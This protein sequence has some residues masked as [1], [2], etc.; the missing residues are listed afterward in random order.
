MKTRFSFLLIFLCFFLL[1]PGVFSATWTRATSNNAFYFSGTTTSSSNKLAGHGSTYYQVSGH[2]SISGTAD[3]LKAGDEYEAEAWLE[4]SGKDVAGVPGRG[5]IKTNK[6]DASGANYDEH[7]TATGEV[8]YKKHVVASASDVQLL[9]GT[10]K[11]KSLSVSS[12]HSWVGGSYTSPSGVSVSPYCYGRLDGV[13]LKSTGGATL[14]PLTLRSGDNPASDDTPDDGKKNL[15]AEIC[16]RGEDCGKPGTATKDISHRVKCGEKRWGNNILLGAIG[17]WKKKKEDCPGYIWTCADPAVCQFV[18]S[19]V[20]A[21]E[22]Q[23]EEKYVDKDGKTV[24]KPAGTD[25]D[26]S[27]S[28]ASLSGSGSASAGSTYKVTLTTPKPFRKLYWYVRVP[29]ASK[30]KLLTTM[31]GGSSST[32]ASYTYYLANSAPAGNHVL[33]VLYYD[34]ADGEAS[35]IE[36]TVSVTSKLMACGHAKGTP[37]NHNYVQC[38]RAKDGARCRADKKHPGYHLACDTSHVHQYG[39]TSTTP[40]SKPKDTTPTDTTPRET[41]PKD[42]TPKETQPQPKS[43]T[44][45]TPTPT[46]PTPTTPTPTTPTPTT[47]VPQAPSQVTYHA[48]GVH[49]SSVSGDHSLQAS[50]SEDSKCIATSFYKCQHSSHTYPVVSLRPCGHPTTRW[51]SHSWVSAGKCSYYNSDGDRCTNTSGYYMCKPHTHEYP[52][53]KKPDPPPK[54]KSACPAD[55]WTNCGGTV[56]HAATCQAGHTYY[57]C[58]PSAVSAHSRH[59]KPVPKSDV[60]CSSGHRYD[61]ES[62][63]AVN[64]HRVRT[65]RFSACGQTWQ[66]CVDVSAPICSKPYRKKNGLSCW[67]K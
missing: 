23:L 20:S 30:S 67:A 46:T 52:A 13:L 62:D 31:Q 63:F 37:G 66:R 59:K 19:H 39:P 60:V 28:S 61:P 33:N 47:P 14:T 64:K 58:N 50:C 38:P 27:S 8:V 43:P 15:V 65:C 40:V 11:A 3:A 1:T 35:Y 12:S 36:H 4:T 2:A 57:T 26:S 10:Y 25:D 29:G 54:P 9:R 45:T 18:A 34:Y 56:S 16:Q 6:K 32:S 44:P 7:R 17:V 5:N 55:S 42:T 51:G 41:Q 49:E 22:S 48:C 24:P 53:P 21:S